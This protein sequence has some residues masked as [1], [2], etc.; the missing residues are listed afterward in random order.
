MDRVKGVEKRMELWEREER[1]RNIIIKGVKLGEWEAKGKVEELMKIMGVEGEV[2]RIR[3]LT[4]RGMIWVRL[5]NE[6]QK[7]EVM[8]KKKALKGRIEWI[9]EDLT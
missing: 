5:N 2:E 7:K 6:R 4:G 8:I 9:E 1:K 3:E